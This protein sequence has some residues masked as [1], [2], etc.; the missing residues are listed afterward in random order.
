MNSDGSGEHERK[1]V[2]AFCF[3]EI[4]T[5]KWPPCSGENGIGGNIRTDTA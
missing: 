5:R 2:Q 3:M 1:N 4:Q